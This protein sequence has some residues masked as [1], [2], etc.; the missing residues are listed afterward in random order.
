LKQLDAK[1]PVE[2]EDILKG[3]N[4][5]ET[6]VKSDN[7]IAPMT[8]DSI[9][10]NQEQPLVSTESQEK[11]VPSKV[12]EIQKLDSSKDSV[13][14]ARK[15]KHQKDNIGVQS[16]EMLKVRASLEEKLKQKG[17]YNHIAPKPSGA[18]K[19]SRPVNGQLETYDDF[20]DDAV[21]VKGQGGLSNGLGSSKVSQ[22][23]KSNLKKPKTFSGRGSKVCGPTVL[24]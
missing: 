7:E 13:Q 16:L 6:G 9:T 2:L 11:A 17:L 23:L 22:F 15:V 4:G 1:L 18:L 21:D 8:T 19:R 20:D 24:V 3:S 14:K 5:L 12:V 10:E